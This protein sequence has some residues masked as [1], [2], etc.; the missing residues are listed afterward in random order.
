V[1]ARLQIAALA[2][3]LMLGC[4]DPPSAPLAVVHGTVTYRGTQLPG[5]LIVFTPDD[6]YGDRGPC[7]EAQ[8]G[9]DGLYTLKTA[10]NAGASVGKH[11]VTIAGPPGRPLPDKFLDPHLSGLRAEVIAGQENVIDF[12][13]EE[14]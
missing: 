2:A 1:T 13:L 7:A 10:G 11:R 8:I 12:K 3:L 4:S 5:G 9:A 6:D 14:R